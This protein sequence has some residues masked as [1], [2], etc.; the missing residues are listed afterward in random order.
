MT[1]KSELDPWRVICAKLFEITSYDIPEIIEKTGLAVD[2]SLSKRQDHSHTYRKSA[3]RPRINNAYELLG[4]Q[5]RLRVA[6]IT[7]SELIGRGLSD[8]LNS[9]LQKIGWSVDSSR[10]IPTTADVSE[11]FF[12]VGTQHDAYVAIRKILQK[13]TSSITIIDPYLDSSLFTVLKTVVGPSIGVELITFKIPSDFVLE[14][15]TFLSQHTSCRLCIKK[16][17]EFHDRFIIVDEKDCWHVGASIKDAGIRVFMLNE[18]QDKEN[19]EALLGQ[20]NTTRSAATE[21]SI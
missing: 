7:A 17:K 10:L 12:P 19:Q 13:A 1:L 3:Y 16:S 18:I 2:W 15:R 11:L 4:E 5:E 21:I 20:L 14:A 9:N 8:E 6:T